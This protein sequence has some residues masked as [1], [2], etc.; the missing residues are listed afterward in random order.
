MSPFKLVVLIFISC[1]F[2]EGRKF[3]NIY[4][5]LDILA[6]P[7]IEIIDKIYRQK[8]PIVNF[9]K[10]RTKSRI[11]DDLVQKILH[12][13]DGNY[14]TRLDEL[15]NIEVIENGTRKYNI[16]LLDDIKSFRILDKQINSQVFSF[17]G[18][19]TF[20]LLNG[21]IKE[22]E[23]IFATLWIKNIF[24][25]V[26]MFES[27]KSIDLMTF[28]PFSG[29]KCDDTTPKLINRFVNGSFE[30]NILTS[31]FPEKFENLNK[32]EIKIATC[33][34]SLGVIL[35]NN[36]DGSVKLS[37][38]DI[39]FIEELSKVMNFKTKINV[40]EG[41]EVWGKVYENGTVDGVLGEVVNRKSQ[42]AISQLYLTPS[43]LKY[44]DSSVTYFTFSE[45]FVISPGRK[46]TSLEKLLQPFDEWTWMIFLLFVL[47]TFA[48]CC[49]FWRLSTKTSR[50]KFYK[51][52][53]DD[54]FDTLFN[55]S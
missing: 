37:G 36:S 21:K 38:I 16:V 33:E 48:I 45:V 27:E 28:M 10:A 20:V 26:I 25:V 40:L 14:T 49:H 9:I 55:S 34:N 31:I 46:L 22:I 13:N 7:V 53:F 32:C 44:A 39:E 29:S 35:S 2:I 51:I 24:K 3:E 42:I 1:G 12:E 11:E 43:K 4:D 54:V 5:N 8:W 17:R 18:Y 15:E 30:K 41:F 23:E 50:E 6:A 47:F 52:S 19:F